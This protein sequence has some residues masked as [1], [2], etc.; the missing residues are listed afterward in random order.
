MLLVTIQD[1]YQY[2][3]LLDSIHLVAMNMITVEWLALRIYK[4][5]CLDLDQ[6]IDSLGAFLSFLSPPR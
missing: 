1:L 6:E 2:F 5:L 4:A 3:E